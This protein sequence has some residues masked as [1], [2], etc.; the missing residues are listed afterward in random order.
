MSVLLAVRFVAELAMLAALAW[1]GFHLAGDTALRLGLAVVLP[2]T[3]AGVWGLWV[4]PRATRRL[5]D[6]A[7]AV[8]ELMLFIAAFVV[9]TRAEPQPHV[10]GWGLAMLVTYLVSMPA[11]SVAR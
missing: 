8:V 7:R 9:L 11:R 10:I 6:P 1:G 4:A 2:V 5:K 3:A